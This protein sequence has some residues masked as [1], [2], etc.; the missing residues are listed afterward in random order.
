MEGD[1]SEGSDEFQGTVLKVPDSGRSF[2][3]PQGG[4]LMNL[5][6]KTGGV[7]SNPHLGGISPCCSLHVAL[8]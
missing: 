8:R 2:G 7:N 1:E 4:I 3:A 6:C 5:T